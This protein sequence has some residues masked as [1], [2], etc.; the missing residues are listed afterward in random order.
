MDRQ[1]HI[2]SWNVK[3]LNH[4]IKR[5]KVLSHL[6]YLK[7]EIAFLKETH[8]CSS[9]NER[10]LSGWKGQHFHSSFQAKA[11]GVSILIG[12]NISLEPHS[13]T[14]DKF[15]RYITVSGKLFNTLV[16]FM[17]VYAPN[18]DDAGFFK[19]LF[20]LLPDL[21]KYTLILGGDLNCWLNPVLDRSSDNI[22]TTSKSASFIQAFLS[23]YGI[24]DVWRTLHPKDRVYSFFSH[25]HHT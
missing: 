21:N 20:S 1:V 16:V 18:S 4:P 7:K 13:V 3:G 12:Q 9:D 19:R 25:V 23:D 8:I 10:L 5:K 14:S 11:R 15:G 17:N 22:G 6:K 2:L 24:C